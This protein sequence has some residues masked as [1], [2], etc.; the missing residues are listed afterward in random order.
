MSCQQSVIYPCKSTSTF[1]LK[2]YLDTHMPLVQ[3]LWG[4]YGLRKWEVLELNKDSGYS[5]QAVLTYDSRE[6]ADKAWNSEIAKQIIDDIPNFS[7]EQP[8]KIVG[9]SVGKAATGT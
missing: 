8:I 9:T 3:R 2:Y 6:D 4:P 5:I 7:N 1:D